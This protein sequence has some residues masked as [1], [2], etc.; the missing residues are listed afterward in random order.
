[1]SQAHRPFYFFKLQ[2]TLSALTAANKTAE[3]SNIKF[4]VLIEYI[5]N[6][7]PIIDKTRYITAFA[8][9]FLISA[10]QSF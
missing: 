7:A 1:M 8:V 9:N 6:I 5:K 3:I 4:L 10:Y 2:N